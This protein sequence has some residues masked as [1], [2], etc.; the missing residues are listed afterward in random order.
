MR[1]FLTLLLAAPLALWLLTVTGTAQQAA[2][3]PAGT[4]SR[5]Q[6]PALAVRNATPRVLVVG[7]GNAALSAALMALESGD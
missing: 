2:P 1:R 5:V 6:G 7:G 4:V 3:L